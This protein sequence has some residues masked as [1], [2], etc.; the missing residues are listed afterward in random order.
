MLSQC[1]SVRHQKKDS[2]SLTEYEPKPPEEP[3]VS[4]KHTMKHSLLLNFKALKIES[5]LV[6]SVADPRK[7][8]S[9]AYCKGNACHSTDEQHCT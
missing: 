2:P 8:G 9:N 7:R 5:L 6:M 4:L 1:I 3:M